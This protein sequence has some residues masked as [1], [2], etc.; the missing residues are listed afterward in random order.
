M[1]NQNNS[2]NGTIIKVIGVLIGI[3]IIIVGAVN[4]FKDTNP[5]Q[6]ADKTNNNEKIVSNETIIS[7]ARTEVGRILKSA[8]T[9]YWGTAEILD[10]DNYGRYLVYVPVE[11][12]N[13][14]GAYGKL[15][16]LVI[17]KDVTADGEYRA[18]TYGSRLEVPNFVGA[19]IPSTVTNYKNGEIVKIV[20][21][22]LEDNNWG[23]AE[24][25]E[26]TSE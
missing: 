2:R 17:V 13:G 6:V 21:D 25:T 4:I 3:I 19:T 14:F 24:I 7:C 22:F 1:E 8:A 20:E 18:L 5:T 15:Y 10:K 9:A 23:Q 16:Y 26:N 12:Q 11:A